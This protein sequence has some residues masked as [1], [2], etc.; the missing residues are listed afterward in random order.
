MTKLP[1]KL[2]PYYSPR[3]SSEISDCSSPL[4]FDIYNK[5]SMKCQYCF[6]AAQKDIHPSIGKSDLQAVHPDTFFNALD[7]TSKKKEEKIFYKYFYK[8][9]F[10]LHLG[11]LADS[12][13]HF[14]KKY[15]YSYPIIKGIL[16]RKYPLMFSS[17]GPMI[18]DEKFTSL[19]EEHADSN[20]TAFQ[21]S[22]VTSDDALAKKVEPGVPSP[23]ERFANMKV[24]S[25]MGYWCI[26][27]L[28]PFIIGITDETLP[29]LLQKAYESG[30]KAVSTEFYAMDNRCVGNMRKATERMGKLMGIDDIFKYFYHLSPSERGGY[31]RLNRLV[32]ETYVKYMYK[33]CCDHDMVFACSDPDYKELSMTQNCCGLPPHGLHS[34][35]SMNNWST[36]QMTSAIMEA[37]LHYHK[38]GECLK[39]HFDEVYGPKDWML[40]DIDLSHQYIGCMN[41]PYAMRKQFTLRLLLQMEWNNLKSYAGPRNYFHGKVMPIGLSDNDNLIY[42]YHPS[43]Y[44]TRWVDEGI[45]LNYDWRDNHGGKN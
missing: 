18:T 37:R 38:T 7:G 25:D 30:A 10:L 21:F 29:E 45:P 31:C 35:S 28:R 39:F 4:T 41:H 27:R 24:L 9:K 12:F 14:E 44:E 33:F 20:T 17:K 1:D 32:K 23:T 19:F 5:C 34:T 22:I 2:D 26:L 6:A 42:Q 40:D 13:C 15:G 16:E 11:G 36:K 43:D 8:D 3:I